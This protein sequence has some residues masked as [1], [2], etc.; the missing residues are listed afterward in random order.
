MKFAEVR[1]QLDAVYSRAISA[2]ISVKQHYP[3]V[4]PPR[5][6][7]DL[8]GTSI[9][10]RNVSYGEI[11]AEFDRHDRYHIKLA[12]GALMQF[13]YSFDEVGELASHRLAY[14]PC[15]ELPSAEEAPDLYAHDELYGDIILE[16]VV[17]FPIRFDFDPGSYQPTYHA[18]SHLTLGQFDN[19]RIPASHPLSPNAFMLFVL[20]N[21]YFRIYRKKQN[22]FEKK[23]P[24]CNS[25]E[26]I[27]ELQRQVT[28]L[29]VAKR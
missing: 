23:I 3:S 14:F 22:V 2:G 16:K 21:F 5:T 6:V 18:H 24:H 27:T 20:R 10:L 12:D 28:S 29:A 9:A 17:R 15:P 25:A 8:G 11:Y 19:C 26:C 7:V 4:S 13:Q 1:K